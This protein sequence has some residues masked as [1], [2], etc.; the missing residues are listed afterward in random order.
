MI[1]DQIN[2][3]K[4]R[5]LSTNQIIQSLRQQ[6]ISPKEINESLSQSEI[7]NEINSQNFFPDTPESNMQPSITNSEQNFFDSSN[8]EQQN[9][10]YADQQMNQSNFQPSIS[11]NSAEPQ[12]QEYPIYKEPVQENYE[13]SYPEYQQSGGTDIETINDVSSQIIE[14][15]IKDFKKEFSKFAEFK[16]ESQNKIEEID[17]RL[18]KIEDRFEELQMAIIR[19]IGDYGEDIENLSKEIMATQDSFGKIINPLAEKAKEVKNKEDQTKT[20]KNKKDDSFE[21]Y[22]R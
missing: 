16:K 22:L 20:T 17:K 11:Q 13:Y 15:K 19:K 6:G 9:Q 4:K 2:Q 7:K 21:N 1:L 14:E 3:M 12:T 10:Y 5:G 18:S 8:S